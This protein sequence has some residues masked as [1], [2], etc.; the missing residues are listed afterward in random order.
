MLK[1]FTKIFSF[2]LI[3]LILVACATKGL[4]SKQKQLLQKEGFNLTEDGWSLALPEQLL[5]EFNKST[6]N[7]SKISQIE[8]LSE[9]LKKYDLKRLK[10]IGHTDN[11]GTPEYNH[12]LSKKRAE[13]VKE[14]FVQ[15]GFRS[16]DIQT[17]GRGA[18]QPLSNNDNI[19]KRAVN[20]RVNIVIIP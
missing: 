13:T 17:I 1:Q 3:G 2:A 5:F 11:I 16:S 14:V 12:A 18:T 19:E 20:R 15:H 4:S 8:Q 9:T 6:I 7:E 10:I